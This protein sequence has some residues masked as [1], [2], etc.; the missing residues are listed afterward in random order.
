MKKNLLFFLI[1]LTSGCTFNFSGFNPRSTKSIAIPV[2]ENE[3][4]RYGIEE[5]MTKS[6]TDAFIQDNRLRVIDRKKAGTVLLG[7]ITSYTRTPFSYDNKNNVKDYKI[8]MGMDLV[9]LSTTKNIG[10]GT[11]GAGSPDT[12]SK[13]NQVLDS[14]TKLKPHTKSDT[15]VAKLPVTQTSDTLLKKQMSDWFAYSADSTEESGITDL[16]AK[17][18]SDIVKL[19]LEQ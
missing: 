17:M 8:E 5:T 14:L 16:C 3:T 2:F 10:S 1:I 7:K 15:A 13:A 18:A 12:S 6:L 19:I 9:Y 4:N 11:Q